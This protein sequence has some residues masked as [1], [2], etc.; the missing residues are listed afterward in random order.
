MARIFCRFLF[1]ILFFCISVHLFCTLPTQAE[2]YP[3]VEMSTSDLKVIPNGNVETQ[4]RLALIQS[5]VESIDVITYDQRMD[6]VVGMP[7]LRLL[8]EKA[9][10]DHVQVRFIRGG[11]F[12]ASHTAYSDHTRLGDNVESYL[13]EPPTRR[14]IQYMMAG[15]MQMIKNGWS[16]FAGAHEKIIIIDKR[17]VLTTG[18]GHAEVYRDWVDMAYLMKGPLVHQTVSAYEVLWKSVA[19]ITK[20]HANYWDQPVA[21]P[22]HWSQS[23]KDAALPQSPSEVDLERGRFNSATGLS[24]GSDL[25]LTQN[26]KTRLEQLKIWSL[27]PEADLS[28][29]SD[30]KKMRVRVLHHDFLNQMNQQCKQ[31]PWF[32]NYFR[33]SEEVRD[34]IL[35]E[36]IHLILDSDKLQYYTLSTVLHPY[37]KRASISRLKEKEMLFGRDF[38]LEII[39][40]GFEAHKTVVPHPMGWWA[41]L[42]DLN[43]L[44]ALGATAYGVQVAAENSLGVRKNPHGYTHRKL[45][46]AHLPGD[47][48]VSL[49]GSHNLSYSST[50][51]ND[52]I[53]FEIES[54]DFAHRMEYYFKKTVRENTKKLQADEIAKEQKKNTIPGLGWAWNWILSVT[55]A[56]F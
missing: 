13:T 26:E 20:R 40:N 37:A 27:L 8:R 4:L 25:K 21:Y 3:W 29:L 28:S 42:E 30:R 18:R 19:A 55:R 31:V 38:K 14:P 41:G 11:F 16:V 15:G 39:S 33:C 49:F 54:K 22:P 51:H 24:L 5:A 46:I 47:R 36:F 43:D 1:T 52:E 35:D 6:E 10:Q 12:P 17:I 23:Q 56:S 45:A 50:I 7:L 32:Y 53:S 48:K 44:L 9:D 2:V 34:P